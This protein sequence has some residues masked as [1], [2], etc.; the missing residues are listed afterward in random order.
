MK[1]IL[2]YLNIPWNFIKQRPQFMAE[3]LSRHFNI[4]VYYNKPYKNTY[5]IESQENS[6]IQRIAKPKIPRKH[7]ILK[8]L[9]NVLQHLYLKRYLRDYEYIWVMHP[10]EYEILKAHLTHQKLIYDCM[11]DY[12]QFPHLSKQAKMELKSL[13]EELIQRADYIFYT[14]QTLREKH[15]QRYE[16]KKT[17]Y[18][19][20]NAFEP[21]TEFEEDATIKNYMKNI[22]H[23][24]LVYIGAI[25][26]WFDIELIKQVLQANQEISVILFGPSEIE[27]PNIERLYHFG[28]IPHGSIY[29]AMK[30]ADALIMPF[31]INE[32][33]LAVDPIKIYEYIYSGKPVIVPDYPEMDKFKEFVQVYHHAQEFIELTHAIQ[34]GQNSRSVDAFIAQNI[35]DARAEQVKQIIHKAPISVLITGA[36]G[37]LGIELSRELD[38]Y[39]DAY[40]IIELDHN[41]LDITDHGQVQVALETY[42]PHIVINCA[43]YT[44][45]DQCEIDIEKAYK[46][47]ELGAKNLAMMCNQL[48]SKLIQVSTDYV[49]DGGTSMDKGLCEND[50]V[51]P[52]NVYGHSKYAG[53]QAVRAHCPKHF[54]LRTAWLYGEGNNFVRTMLKLAQTNSEI[55]VVD[56]QFGTPTYAKDLAKV[57]IELMQTEYYGTYHA[58]C[59]G[60][61]SWYEFACEIFRLKNINIKVNQVTSEAFTRPAKRPKYAVLENANLKKLGLNTF[62]PW[63]EALVDYLE[64]D[65]AWQEEYLGG[66]VNG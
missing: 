1:N 64:E 21:I 65:K 40:K 4:L 5:L 56:D 9:D 48:E 8:K 2:M 28:K 11:D 22:K 12:S 24:K 42:R 19:I 39:G 31:C 51:S 52:S 27:L 45:V 30:Y 44:Q 57:I 66:H 47:N 35:W 32:L 36:K 49:F 61:C 63:Q 20:N 16:I 13:E 55:N 14:S 58:T 33:I 60:S 15:R 3:K 29:T 43:A 18:V 34:E 53:E 25:A 38:A 37:Q 46:V 50:E 26:P 62:R 59:E 17:T 10:N 54:I 7:P 6:D 23:K 41:A